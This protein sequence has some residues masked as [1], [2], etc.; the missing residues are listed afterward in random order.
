MAKQTFP[1]VPDDA[2]IDIKVSGSFYKKLLKL[3]VALGE[4][5]PLEDYK[6][7][8]ETLGKEDAEDLYELTVQSVV[9][10]LFEVETA[11][12]AQNKTKLM[13]IDLET[14]EMSD[15]SGS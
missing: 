2:M 3:S 9:S 7:A 6:K 8:L 10:M 13:E 15:P 11:A 12:K 1:V 5:R 14:G 4:S